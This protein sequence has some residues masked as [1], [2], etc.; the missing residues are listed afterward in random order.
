MVI[1][2]LEIKKVS[3]RVGEQLEKMIIYGTFQAGEKLPSVRELCEL[4]GVGR[5][6]VRDAITVLKGKGFVD[7]KQGDGTYVCGFDSTKLFKQ[8]N[9]PVDTKDLTELF[10]VRKIMETGMV[11]IAAKTRNNSDISKMK[12]TLSLTNVNGWEADYQFHKLIA[13]AT[14]NVIFIQLS[15]FISDSMK[16]TMIDFYR[17]IENQEQTIL[18]INQQHEQL[19]SFIELGNALAAKEMMTEHLLFVE[20]LFLQSLKKVPR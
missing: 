15:E 16:Q 3:D 10:Q 2:K 11:E 19:V 9:I 17:Y 20:D 5:S 12:E 18:K 4:F 13:V 8:T 1:E 6:A 14:G 7:V